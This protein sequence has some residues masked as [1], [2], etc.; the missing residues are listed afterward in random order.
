MAYKA[1]IRRDLLF[2]R[3]RNKADMRRGVGFDGLGRA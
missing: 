1:D 3:F 2:V